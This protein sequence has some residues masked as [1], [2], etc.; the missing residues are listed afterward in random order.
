MPSSLPDLENRNGI[1]ENL[2]V[3]V[4]RPDD[5]QACSAVFNAVEDATGVE[6]LMNPLLLQSIIG[7]SAEASLDTFVV[8]SE[9][10]VIGFAGMTF[11]AA[12]GTAWARC[13][14]HP[15]FWGKGIGT[16]LIQRTDARILQRAERETPAG[17][18]VLVDRYLS[19]ANVG[20][21]RLCETQGYIHLR[22]SYEMRIALD[23]P[24]QPPVLPP[25][26]S[27]RPFEPQHARAVF[28]AD[29]EAFAENRDNVDMS[30][31]EW[32]NVL[33]NAPDVDTSVWQIAYAGDE[34]AGYTLSR[35][36]DPDGKHMYISVVGVRRAWRRRGLGEALLRHSFAA[37]Q[38]RGA[39][40]AA[41][42]VD[43]SNKTNAVT[44]YERAG[45]HIHSRVLL[46]RKTLRGSVGEMLA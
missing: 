45:M 38:A 10:R 28:D 2:T 44:L 39:V 8:E 23:K 43:A 13:A 11:F 4:Y 9:H 15:D 26:F 42:H 25:E 22:D 5:L 40:Q 7:D 33:M 34:V 46:Y 24:T 35:R 6:R 32:S 19:A 12:A 17:I 29:S 41:L 31:E 14:V 37:F 20:A 3:R 16:H 1:I 18:P 27:L 36:D 21:A 30:F